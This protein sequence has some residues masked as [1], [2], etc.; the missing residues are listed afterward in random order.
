MEIKQ[1]LVPLS[2]YPIKCPYS[3]TPIGICIHN[4][5]NDAS[6]K[7]E[8]SYMVANDSQTSYHFAIDDIEIWQ[9]LP[10]NRNGWHAGDGASGEGNRKY[11][12]IE[13][14]YSKSGGPKF[15]KAEDRTAQ[16]VALLLKERGWGIDR[17]KKHQDFTLKNCPHRTLLL[18]W[19]RFLNKISNYLQGDMQTILKQTFEE[20]VGKSSQRDKVVSEY[21]LIIGIGKDTELVDEIKK[22]VENAL[23]QAS[24]CSSNLKKAND[25]LAITKVNLAKSSQDLKDA[26]ARRVQ[27]EN[28][29]K[30]KQDEIIDLNKALQ[31]TGDMYKDEKADRAR[32]EKQLKEEI[33]RL[34][35]EGISSSEACTKLLQSIIDQLEGYSG[36]KTVESVINSI[37]QREATKKRL[38]DQVKMYENN[39]LIKIFNAIKELIQ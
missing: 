36:E 25:E 27:A 29:L 35:T 31:L 7:N 14:C 11:I 5:F 33:E 26:N 32:V 22:I 10:L 20:L 19:Q 9:G 1:N 30:D 13:I 21:N 4:T 34:K 28:D 39:L 2:K 24:S 15:D 18:G 37:S 16:F 8:I 6:A 23:L 17:V 12:A 3:M 38:E